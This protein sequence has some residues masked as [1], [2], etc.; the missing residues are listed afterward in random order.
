MARKKKPEEEKDYTAISITVSKATLAE[1]DKQ[2][3]QGGNK[4]RSA[5]FNV[6]AEEKLA[7]EKAA[8]GLV[9]GGRGP[10]GQ[11]GGGGE[12]GATDLETIRR[13][14]REEID[15][16]L[17]GQGHDA[18]Q[19]QGANGGPADD[20]ENKDNRKT[21]PDGSGLAGTFLDIFKGL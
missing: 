20:P 8:G 21:G 5:F 19:G 7:R 2:I 1:V 3:G 12:S 9:S 10:G 17:G 18:G 15:R 4:S 13:L 16:R 14:V 11:G 6:A